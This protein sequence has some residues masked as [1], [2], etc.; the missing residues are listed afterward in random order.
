MPRYSAAV[1]GATG[2]LGSETVRRL[3]LHPEVEVV[4][5][6]ATT[7]DRRLSMPVF[8][9]AATAVP[10]RTVGG[11][12]FDYLDLEDGCVGFTLGDVAGKGM[13]AAMIMA[14]AKAMIPLVAAGRPVDESL[15]ELNSRLLQDLAAREFVALLVFHLDPARGRFELANAGLPDP[16]LLRSGEPLQAL[17]R[18]G[19][20]HVG[21]MSIVGGP[22][23]PDALE[24]AHQLT[25][26]RPVQV[27]GERGEVGQRVGDGR[28]DFEPADGAHDRGMVA[29]EARARRWSPP[30][31]CTRRSAAAPGSKRRRTGRDGSASASTSRRARRTASSRSTSPAASRPTSPPPAPAPGRRRS[32]ARCPPPTWAP[33]PRSCRPRRS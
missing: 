17:G 7:E 29:A 30:T 23:R 18:R 11:D 4:D 13:G 10:S 2:Y 8:E 31:G 26:P 9:I 28:A 15:G 6:P 24:Q 19:A 33:A 16:Y 21:R 14:S 22:A 20:N 5:S 25:V 32:T 12:F 1:Y 27:R 3:L